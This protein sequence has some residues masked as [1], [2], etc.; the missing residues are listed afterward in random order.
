MSATHYDDREDEGCD[1]V[2]EGSYYELINKIF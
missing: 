2:P 1:F